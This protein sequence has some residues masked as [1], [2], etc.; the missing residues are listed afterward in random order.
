M[1]EMH[2]CSSVER[3]NTLSIGDFY[4]QVIP[5]ACKLPVGPSNSLAPPP[6]LSSSHTLTLES[7]AS[8]SKI[9][10]TTCFDLIEATSSGDYGASSAGWHP[11]SK[12]REMRLPD[13]KY[14]IVHC[15]DTN[16]DPKVEAFLSFMLTYE[17]GF[18]VVYCYE[19]HMLPRLRGHGLGRHLVELMEGVGSLTGVEKAMLTVFVRNEDAMKFYQRLGYAEDDFGPEPRKLRNG[20]V[21]V[22]DYMILSKLLRNNPQ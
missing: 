22:P 3:A 14:L 2:H 16:G 6:S 13:L 8:I 4:S 11:S 19:V 7:A 15:N 18:E 12:R 17:D 21:K 20:V 5:A 1:D 9:D 10:L